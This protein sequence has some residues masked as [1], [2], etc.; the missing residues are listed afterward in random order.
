MYGKSMMR[1]GGMTN[2]NAKVFAS[3]IAKGTV[4]GKSK[5]PKSAMPKAKMGMSMK[6]K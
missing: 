3:K 5:A 2:S 4:G 1:T 6:K